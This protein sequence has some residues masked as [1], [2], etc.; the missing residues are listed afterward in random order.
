MVDVI[1]FNNQEEFS[2]W[3]EEHAAEASELW[4]GYFRKSTGRASLTW[5]T[6]VGVTLC[7]GWISEGPR[8]WSAFLWWEGQWMGHNR[9]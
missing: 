5:S 9:R 1:F 4:V 8:V 2:D 3:L 6:S 7:F